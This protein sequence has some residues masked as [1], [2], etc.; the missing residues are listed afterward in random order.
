MNWQKE[1]C[2]VTARFE[3]DGVIR[4]LTDFKIEHRYGTVIGKE[5]RKSGRFSYRIKRFKLH[6]VN[7]LTFV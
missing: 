6:K 4:H 2:N 5:F 3:Y 1:G 7:H